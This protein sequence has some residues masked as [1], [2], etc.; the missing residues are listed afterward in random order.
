MIPLSKETFFGNTSPDLKDR[1]IAELEAELAQ[2]IATIRALREEIEQLKA[3][4]DD[5]RRKRK[6]QATPFAREK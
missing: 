6:R 4:I 5:L 3:K 2:A 1:R